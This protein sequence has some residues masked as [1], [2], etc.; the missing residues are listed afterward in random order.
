M[1]VG[2]VP[3]WI[4]LAGATLLALVMQHAGVPPVHDPVPLVGPARA[5]PPAAP[6]PSPT[7]EARAGPFALAAIV[8]VVDYERSA[9]P[10][11]VA[12]DANAIAY[13]M[14]RPRTLAMST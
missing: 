10:T 13:P 7:T 14:A 8:P 2:R 5:S 3:L 12:P 6:P 1:K 11:A 4:I 9:D